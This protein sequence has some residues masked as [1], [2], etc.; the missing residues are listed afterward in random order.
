MHE[1]ENIFYLLKKFRILAKYADFTKGEK[2][3]K[4]TLCVFCK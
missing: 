2:I 4:K 1:T 3:D